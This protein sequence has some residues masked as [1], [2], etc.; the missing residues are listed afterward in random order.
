MSKN[1]FCERLQSLREEKGIAKGVMAELLGINRVSYSYYEKGTNAPDYTLIPKLCAILGVSADYL[2]GMSDTRNPVYAEIANTTG[3][4][5][6][7]I[8]FLNHIK[9]KE[10][11]QIINS[12]LREEVKSYHTDNN[13]TVSHVVLYDQGNIDDKENWGF[14]FGDS[15]ITNQNG[16]DT[17]PSTSDENKPPKPHLLSEIR[18]YLMYS[19]RKSMDPPWYLRPI[20]CGPRK[21]DFVPIPPDMAVELFEHYLS[22]RVLC[23]LKAFRDSYRAEYEADEPNK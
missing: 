22:E 13:G 23:A 1:V 11:L 6:V 10:T 15:L 3:L 5:E 14:A 12:L 8:E 2:L 9:N 7:S 20:Y 16:N 19:E 18:M 17:E 4:D 21:S